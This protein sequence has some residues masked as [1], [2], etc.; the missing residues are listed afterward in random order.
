MATPKRRPSPDAVSINGRRTSRKSDVIQ[1][2]NQDEAVLETYEQNVERPG[3]DVRG[4]DGPDGS[5]S[6]PPERSSPD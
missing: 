3:P 6:P 2:P 5:G 4:N 1:K